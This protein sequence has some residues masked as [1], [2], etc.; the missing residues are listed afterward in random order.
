M[1]MITE[2]VNGK[3]VT[4]TITDPVEEERIYNELV[5]QQE[6]PATPAGAAQ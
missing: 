1:L 5:H 6:K 3:P 4:R 2:M